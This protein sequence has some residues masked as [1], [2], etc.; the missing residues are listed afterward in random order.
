MTASR[1]ASDLAVFA[2]AKELCSYVM[3]CTQKSP[4]AFRFTCVTRMQ[5]LALD[6][7]E[8]LF[9]ANDVFASKGDRQSLDRRLELQRGAPTAAEP[10][11]HMSEMA[12]GRGRILPRRF[13]R[14]A[15]LSA[16]RQNTTG[17]WMNSDGKRSLG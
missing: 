13:E 3:E 14:V 1:P 16:D 11:C 17:A 6:V 12:M 8:R 5:S 7:V 4:E 15:C 10:L 2:K 9:R